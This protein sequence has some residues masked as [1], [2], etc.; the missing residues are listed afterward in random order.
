MPPHALAA[1]SSVLSSLGFR[2]PRQAM[3]STK[4]A[5]ATGPCHPLPGMLPILSSAELLAN[6]RASV[7]RIE[8]LAGTTPAHFECY[9]LDTLHRFARWCQQRPASQPN[10]ARPGG[11]LDKGME[12]AAAALKIRQGHLLP[13]GTVPEQAVLKK[14]LWT[15]AV[16][17]LGLLSD[18]AKPTAQQM[19]TLSDGTAS[20]AWNPWSSAMDDDPAVRGYRLEASLETENHAHV[21]DSAS[22]M[23]ANLI[24]APAGLAWLSSDASVFSAWLACASGDKASA[25]ILGNILGKASSLPSLA[26]PTLQKT[27]SST[28]LQTEPSIL[29]SP[30]EWESRLILPISENASDSF[31]E[32]PGVDRLTIE[33][34]RHLQE[35]QP[36]ELTQTDG[37][38][39]KEAVMG[40]AK[41]APAAKF[42]EWL[43]TGIEQGRIPYNDKDARVHVVPEGVL[44]V[45]P[46]IF[47]DFTEECG[48]G[49]W[50]TVQ[51]L[52]IKRKQHVKTAS[53]E[54]I[55]QYEVGS[56]LSQTVLSGFLLK[57]PSLVFGTFVPDFNQKLMK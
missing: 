36:F 46:N 15:F 13:P 41:E 11:L 40:N 1:F 2:Q 53:G 39:Q 54:N 23:L 37:A 18:L 33:E 28:I 48:G 42:M 4:P 35:N 52:F 57:D 5:T 29:P 24:I 22:L 50:D 12:T 51:K 47:K 21:P 56:G 8:E 6:R 3:P 20:W 10:H 45:T 30:P 25:G 14:D 27:T 9:Y 19:V 16:F 49:R 34:I 38:Q 31:S 55:H 26:P 43:C 32:L 44:L 17:T 7:S